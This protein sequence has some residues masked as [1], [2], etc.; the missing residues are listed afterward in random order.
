MK[1][2]TVHRVTEVSV[3]PESPGPVSVHEGCGLQQ[4]V[5][6]GGGMPFLEQCQW[7]RDGKGTLTG[8]S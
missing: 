6:R 3:Y 7:R 4:V 1:G 8:F 5:V 2:L